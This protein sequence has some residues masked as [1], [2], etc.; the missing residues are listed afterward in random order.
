MAVVA[1]EDPVDDA[2]LG[3]PSADL[4]R[5]GGSGWAQAVIHGERGERAAAR[6]SPIASKQ[7]KRHAVG[8]AGDRHG[9]ARPRLEGLETRHER[10]EF[11]R[12]DRR[13]VTG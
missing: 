7:N 6:R 13:R 2:A 1:R 10:G 11:R 3:E 12:A 4:R 9:E 5:F 8:A